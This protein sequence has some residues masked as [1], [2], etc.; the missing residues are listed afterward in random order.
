MKKKAYL[1]HAATTPIEPLALRAMLPYYKEKFGNPSSIHGWGQEARVAVDGARDK[2][3][4]LMACQ[5]EEIIFTGTVT[6]TDNLAIQGVAKALKKQGR[7]LVTSSVEHHAVLDVFKALEQEGFEVTY[8]PVDQF[9]KVSLESLKKALTPKT[10]LVS[11]MLA[12]NEVGT[13]Q[14]VKK[15][16][17]IIK[18]RREDFKTEIYLHTDVAAAVGW[19]DI[20]PHQLGAD[21]ISLGAHKFGGPKGVGL[22]YI[23]EGAPIKPLFF[24]GH[25]E[26]GLWPG[27]E[28]VPLIV[29][30]SK[31]MEIA[32]SGAKENT[33]KV[34][35]LRDRLI[36][37]VAK[38]PGARLI[39][40]PI[41]RLPDIASFTIKGVEGE[42]ML[43]L[44]SDK[45]IAASSGSACTSG[46]LKPSHVLLAMGISSQEAHGSIRFSLGP[47]TTGEEIGY[48]LEVFPKV[49]SQLR[50][51]RRGI[52]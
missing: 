21:L 14:P 2:I 23:R 5:P 16:A 36:G 19:Q 8:L 22:L 27:T 31:A 25:H 46:Q 7:H 38:I 48:T 4:R 28:A 26:K 17:E 10:T 47:K 50:R 9:G 35:Q 33:V 1:D 32:V 29:A 51:L 30:M 37:G 18:S 11:I 42:A 20:R 44:L 34:A 24:G 3:A 15:V 43:L 13:I 40:H 39:G 45:G 52:K 41:N 12:N 6:T 49:I